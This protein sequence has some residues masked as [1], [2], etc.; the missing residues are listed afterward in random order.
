MK[1]TKAMFIDAIEYNGPN[2]L[3]RYRLGKEGEEK[4]ASLVLS[5]EMK[6][7]LISI[8]AE[9]LKRTIDVWKPKEQVK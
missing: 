2:T 7:K 4:E 3:I 1:T 8:L 9:D 6:V 5:P